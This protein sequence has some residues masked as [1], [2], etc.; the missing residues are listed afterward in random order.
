MN[1][2]LIIYDFIANNG[3]C[4]NILL[5]KSSFYGTKGDVRDST[6]SRFVQGV[7]QI[8]K[9]SSA[10]YQVSKCKLKTIL[11]KTNHGDIYKKI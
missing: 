9:D 4:S 11:L 3:N 7:R 8:G 10:G 6:S 1:D 2:V 5:Q